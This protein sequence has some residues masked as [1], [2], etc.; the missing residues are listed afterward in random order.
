MAMTD[1]GPAFDVAAGGIGA[2]G[3]GVRK[4]SSGQQDCNQDESFHNDLSDSHGPR[5]CG[6]IRAAITEQHDTEH[7]K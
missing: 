1:A 2:P 4:A 3:M 5:G 7:G 6:S